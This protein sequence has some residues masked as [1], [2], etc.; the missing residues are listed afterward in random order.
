[1]KE[2]I[3]AGSIRQPVHGYRLKRRLLSQVGRFAFQSLAYEYNNHSSFP[4]YLY[5]FKVYGHENGSVRMR[6]DVLFCVDN[7]IL[8]IQSM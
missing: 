1:M 2:A 8:M 4:W 5:F 3:G 6:M 7:P